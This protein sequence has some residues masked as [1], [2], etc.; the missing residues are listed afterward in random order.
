MKNNCSKHTILFFI[1]CIYSAI[2]SG[3]Q[4]TYTG[5]IFD[6]VTHEPLA[7]ASVIIEG[8]SEGTITGEQGEFI[9]STTMNPVF[10]TIH[11][12]G[13]REKKMSLNSE[14]KKYRILLIPGAIETEEV[15]ITARD[16]RDNIE[17]SS[18]GQ[19]TL[20][21]K[22]LK[23]LPALMG[24]T[25]VLR[26]VQLS[27]GVQAAN[28][29]NSGF[30]VRGG[31]VDQNMILL[32]N[33]PVYNPSHVLGF[34]SVFNA[35]AVREVNLM[36]AGIPA[37]YG[38]RLS[39]VLEVKSCD[40]NQEAYSVQGNIGLI[41]GNMT[42][43]GPLVKN[44]ASWLVSG[45]R[46]YIDEVLKPLM[47]PVFEKG[48]SFI[49][50]SK[51]HFYDINLK[52]WLKP[53]SNGLVTFTAYKGE[54]HYTLTKVQLNYNNKMNWGNTV[55]SLNW[56][57]RFRDDVYY[58]QHIS[59][60]AYDFDFF[61]YQNE[62]TIRMLSAI[63]DYNVK[64]KLIKITRRGVL[65]TGFDYCRHRFRP[66]NLD[67]TASDIGLDFGSNRNLY[68]HELGMFYSHELDLGERLK[69]NYGLRFSGFIHVGP[70]ELYERDIQDV[71]TDTNRYS[72]GKN[73]VDYYGVEPRL[74]VR[75]MLDENS[76][77]KASVTRHYQ[78]IHLASASN[79][80]VPLDAW[81][82]STPVIKPQYGNQYSAGYYRNIAGNTYTS[83]V[84]FYYKTMHNQ[85]ELLYGL[86]NNFADNTFDQSVTFGEGRAYGFEFYLRK[87]TG[88]LQ[89]WLGYTLSKTEKN[90]DE[91]N[92]GR[93]YPAKYDRTHD[94]NLLISFAVNEKLTLSATFIYATGN[95]YTLPVSKYL[96]S[97]NLVTMYGETNAFRM[98]DYHRMDM[99]LTYIAK[100]TKTFESVFNLS[101]FN[102][103]SRANPF[104][105]YFK[106]EGDPQSS[107][108]VEPVQISLFPIIPSISWRFTF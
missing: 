90:F 92:E 54:D 100:K 63:D 72:A 59:Y 98:P 41:S 75:Y 1:L 99:S 61:A 26:A 89:G 9:L 103:Y 77:V 35:D 76:A 57:H 39:S 84:E 67:V 73:V 20:T 34:F 108:T 80:T 62:V 60:S 37:D 105:I 49:N 46:T 87:V 5:F 70:Y 31:G 36:K 79:V 8:M 44:K 58:Q 11:F 29:G 74:S 51:Y 45:R 23:M 95:A 40:G 83:S 22:D 3:Q 65:K 25:D 43:Q 93:I 71:I 27:P 86:I 7:G 55:Y 101:V 32:D 78:Y 66:N 64:G 97:S 85:V 30:Y 104:Y 91:I 15:R 28:E 18:T 106:V 88:N 42:V 14:D 68:S 50:N 4:Y 19:I 17:N 13:F 47:K 69:I 56:S 10:I 21:R 52:L 24:E 53:Y 16:P 2:C 6:S 107:L 33:A 12:L 48:A 81:L 94:I 96:I 82:P 102:V 38:G